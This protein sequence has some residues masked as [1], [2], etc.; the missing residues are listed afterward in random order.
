LLTPFDIAAV[1]KALLPIKKN[2]VGTWEPLSPAAIIAKGTIAKNTLH[3]IFSMVNPLHP[4]VDNL[5]A[6]INTRG[7]LIQ[8]AIAPSGYLVMTGAGG[9]VVCAGYMDVTRDDPTRLI[10]DQTIYWAQVATEDEA[11]YLTGLLNS[12]AIN[13]IIKE[14]QPRG[15]FGERHV[16]K[17]PFGVTPPY[18]ADQPAHQDVVINTRAL[19]QAYAALKVMQPALLTLLNPNSGSLSS[20]RK[21][22]MQYIK[23]LPPYQL[24]EEACR[25]L[26]GI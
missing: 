19:M 26:Y 18:D 9:G 20:R 14:F 21:K 15:A 4:S 3:D 10:I 12:D 23:N 25:A 22:L 1:Q 11:I 5:F 2:T 8:Q 7:K 13:E 16:H 17:L 6:L 24:Y